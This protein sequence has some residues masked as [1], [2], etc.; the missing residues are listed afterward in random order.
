MHSALLVPIKLSFEGKRNRFN[1]AKGQFSVTRIATFLR[2]RRKLRVP[3]RKTQ[4]EM[5]RGGAWNLYGRFFNAK[6]IFFLTESNSFTSV[7]YTLEVEFYWFYYLC[8]YFSTT[9]FYFS[10]TDFYFST[11]TF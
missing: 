11:T 5:V 4:R 2:R 1:K 9:T 3:E 8:Y 6:N 7:P 10:Y